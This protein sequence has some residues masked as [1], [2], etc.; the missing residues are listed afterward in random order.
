MKTFLVILLFVSIIGLTFARDSFGCGDTGKCW[1]SCNWGA[2]WCYTGFTC[3]ST[4]ECNPDAACSGGG[5]L[6][7]GHCD[8]DWSKK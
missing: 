3:S 4:N 1:T 2:G 6:G 8:T 5:F 7:L